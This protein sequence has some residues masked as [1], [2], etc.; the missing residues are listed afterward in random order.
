MKRLAA[1]AL[2]LLA[3]CASSAQTP[4]RAEVLDAFAEGF[5]DYDVSFA[6][7]DRAEARRLMAALRRDAASLGEAR[8]ELELARVAALARNGHSAVLAPPWRARHAQLGIRFL[9]ADDGLFVADARPGYEELIGARVESIE[10]R[11]LEELRAAW[12]RYAP[13][14]EG[15]RDQT[16]PVLL[17]TPVLLHAAGIARDSTRVSLRLGDGRDVSVGTAEGW[18]APEGM[19]RYLPQSRLIE[20]AVAGRVGGEPLYLGDPGATFRMIPLPAHDAVYVQFRANIDFSGET[21]LAQ[22]ARAAIDSLRALA[23]RFVIVD[24]RFNVGGDLNTTRALMQAIPAITGEDG[25]V[26]A[27][28]SGRTFSAGISSV[29]YLKQAAGDRI[30]IVGAP[31]GDELEFHAEGSPLRLPNGML[32]LRATERHNYRTGCPED[33]CH[34]SIRD[35]PIRVESL[36]PDVRPRFDFEDV[37]SGRDPYLDEVL[38]RIA[39]MRGGR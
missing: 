26:F 24:Q 11:A 22:V 19:W 17:E 33:D 13:G 10:G 39:G 30:T 23:P 27:I 16:L 20:L 29:G 12:A 32:V 6:D 2:L 5:V 25:H 4:T 38:A 35:H 36:E 9:I 31:V 28:T 37:I 7:G 15:F 14:R 21:D 8:F 34:G 1:I 3:P 18:P